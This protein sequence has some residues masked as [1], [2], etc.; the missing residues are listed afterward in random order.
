MPK[1]AGGCKGINHHSVDSVEDTILVGDSI[2]Q[3]RTVSVE[4]M[5]LVD[6][7]SNH[8]S[9]FPVFQVSDFPD[10]SISHFLSLDPLTSHLLSL[11]EIE[12]CSKSEFN[13]KGNDKDDSSVVVE[14]GSLGDENF[15]DCLFT[16]SIDRR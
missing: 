3:H 16:L 2:S 13:N 15:P 10:H 14:G 12:S 11:S 5:I 9:D 7:I 4:D 6:S 1:P 8:H